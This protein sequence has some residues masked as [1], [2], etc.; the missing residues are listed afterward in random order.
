MTGGGGRS[1]GRP[2]TSGYAVEFRRVTR[3]DFP[4]L[5]RWLAAPPVARWWNHEWTAE[6]VERD[7][8]PSVDG[9]EP[10]ED[11]LALLDGAPVGLVQRSL[12]VA[13]A[14]N[15][16]DFSSL[17]EVPQGAVTLDY[18]LGDPASLGRGL[19]TAMI[20]AML[21]CTWLDFPDV[22]TVLVSVVAAN[23]ASWRA[24]EKA[25]F[26][27]VAEGD[28]TPDNP[29]DDPLHYILRLDRPRRA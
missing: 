15:L 11:W 25:G 22:P 2:P 12:V 19:G 5:A 21:E 28:L 7:F 3:A 23:T 18:L 4:L 8:G 16:A 6:A 14:E 10:N 29:V 24:L 9:T 17:V 13:Y 1:G 26:H 27:R 20:A